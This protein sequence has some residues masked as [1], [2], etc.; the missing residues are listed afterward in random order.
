MNLEKSTE[1]SKDLDK[2]AY[3]I[4]EIVNDFRNVPLTKLHIKTRK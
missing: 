3:E 4:K 1:S 2:N